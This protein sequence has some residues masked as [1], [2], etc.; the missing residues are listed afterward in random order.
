LQRVQPT[1]YASTMRTFVGLALIVIT[2]C[3]IATGLAGTAHAKCARSQPGLA[4]PAGKVPANP[5]LWLFLPSWRA[6]E[7]AGL[8]RLR[9]TAGGGSVPVHIEADT[10]AENLNTYRVQVSASRA[11]ALAVEL[12][13]DQGEVVRRWS[14]EVD[15]AWR[16]PAQ[17]A[18][19]VTVGHEVSQWTCSHTRTRNLHFPA[20]AWA[21][22]IVAA[23]TRE[24]LAKG[25]GR[26][27][28]LPRAIEQLWGY[29]PAQMAAQANVALGYASC[30]GD[31][32]D[33]SGGAV[34]ATV[35]ALLPDGSQ[36]PVT[37][38]PLALDPP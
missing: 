36:Q 26:A 8:P 23:P 24:A 5:V 14:L 6:P 4:P 2:S 31:T 12:L 33:W 38:T 16:A 20:A 22:R 29:D 1:A 32:F 27:F 11:G 25:Q 15:P 17:K 34:V 9:A 13:D 28:V 35:V 21:Y 3:A 37:D 30:F 7:A 18:D 10:K 19:R